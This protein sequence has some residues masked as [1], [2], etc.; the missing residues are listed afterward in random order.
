MS[1]NTGILY[2]NKV[3]VIIDSTIHSVLCAFVFFAVV[4]RYSIAEESP[5][6]GCFL[7]LRYFKMK[8]LLSWLLFKAAMYSQLLSSFQYT[9]VIHWGQD[10]CPLAVNDSLCLYSKA[11][12]LL[13][14]PSHPFM[15]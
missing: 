14:L 2:I 5:T 8:V 15:T 6:S 11:L 10:L 9:T 3:D 1:G 7:L 13:Q 12:L 4:R